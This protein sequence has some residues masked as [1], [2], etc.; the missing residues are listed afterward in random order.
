[1]LCCHLIFGESQFDDSFRISHAGLRELS[2]REK[3][4]LAVDL[5][6]P[7]IEAAR[8][9]FETLNDCRELRDACGELDVE[10]TFVGRP[11]IM[12]RSVRPKLENQTI[13]VYGNWGPQAVAP[14]DDD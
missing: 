4:Q 13:E 11:G 2:F 3:A 1:M 6:L 7:V 8:T 10:G 14:R 9:E 5:G 12:V